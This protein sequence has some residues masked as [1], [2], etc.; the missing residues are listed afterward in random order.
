MDAHHQADRLPLATN[1]TTE[2][3]MIFTFKRKNSSRILPEFYKENNFYVPAI[4]WL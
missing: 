3:N 1:G 2:T 4:P